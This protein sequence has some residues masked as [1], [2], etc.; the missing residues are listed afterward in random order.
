MTDVFAG[1]RVSDLERAVRW[2]SSLLGS[3]EAFRPN[4]EEAVWTVSEHGHLYV[5]VDPDRAGTGLVT[6]FV[7]D[8]DDALATAARGGIEPITLETYDNGVRKA[9]FHDPDG[10][11]LGIGG[12]PVD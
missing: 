12:G 3:A 5:L 2:C 9:T 7:D 4:D 6:L 8:L 11:E 1:L 10:N